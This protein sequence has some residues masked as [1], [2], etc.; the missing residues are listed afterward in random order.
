MRQT[1]PTVVAEELLSSD[2]IHITLHKSNTG[3]AIELGV[4][5][6][7]ERNPE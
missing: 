2:Q 1:W 4:R 5:Q 6:G 3:F 7:K